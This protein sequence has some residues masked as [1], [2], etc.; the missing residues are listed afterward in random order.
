VS[1]Y[2]EH[3]SVRTTKKEQAQDITDRVRAV[4]RTSH[5]RTG[6][7]TIAVM[8]T[9]AGVFVNENADPDVLRDVLSALRRA[10]PDD[11]DYRHAEGNAPAHIRTMLTGASTTIPIAD[12]ELALGTWQGIFLAEFDG[13]RER[14]LLV[15]VIGD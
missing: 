15:T 13:P 4:V 8:H 3:V 10:V 12:G 5:V 9:T 11:A 7:C 14:K 2:G 6:I 1:A